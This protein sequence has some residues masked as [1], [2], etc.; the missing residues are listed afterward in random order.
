MINM[1]YMKTYLNLIVL[2]FS[3][4]YKG[5]QNKSI[6]K[7]INT[8]AIKSAVN[9]FYRK[10]SLLKNDNIFSVSSKTLNAD[11][12]EI[13]IIGNS[14][15]F[16]IN[17]DKPLNRIPTNYIEHDNKIF[18]WYDDNEEKLNPSIINKLQEYGLIEYN[19]DIIEFGRD[20]KKKG[21]SYYFCMKNLKKCKKV[22]FTHLKKTPKLFCQ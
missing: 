21:I 18:Y 16:Y 13:N 9:D 12:I 2:V 15:K 10:S 1:T 22:K 5:Q 6:P 8:E 17:D 11:I 19:A 20:D 14:N 3:L 7:D 4:F